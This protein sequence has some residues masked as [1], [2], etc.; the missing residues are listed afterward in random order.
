MRTDSALSDTAS[1][2]DNS[3]PIGD[4]ST[5]EVTD[6]RGVG[7]PGHP[8]RLVKSFSGRE[9]NHMFLSSS[10][11]E[12]S[13]ISAVSGLDAVSDSRSFALLDYDRDG[14]QDIA[15]VNSN[16]PL[17]NL[18]HNEIGRQ[19]GPSDPTGHVVALR[20]HG[21]NRSAQPS[22]RYSAHDGFGAIVT[23]DLGHETLV[24]EHRAGEGFAAQNS[25]TMIVGVGE[26]DVVESVAVAWP[27]G[28]R[29]ELRDVAAGRLLTVFE[30]PAASPTGEAFVVESYRVEMGRDMFT[31]L[32]VAEKVPTLATLPRGPRVR[33]QVP[34]NLYMTMATW[35]AVCARELPQIT[36][37]SE[38]FGQSLALFGLPIDPED[39]TEKLIEYRHRHDPA[40]RLLTSVTSEERAA[41]RATLVDSLSVDGLPSTI[42]TDGEGRVL[43]MSLGL[44]TVSEV[45]RLLADQP[46]SRTR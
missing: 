22:T 37:L 29:Q 34:F 33:G 15:L 11:R 19:L 1:G 43:Q 14:W 41:I 10:G 44:P 46:R 45:R 38:A 36:R 28:S 31:D 2:G 25:A 40:Y 12:F 23:I 26:H 5:V 3:S 27:S 35:C 32:A 16:A 4:L 17:L 9:R 21:G 7:V 20:F 30:D 42:I 18:F 39:S 6:A 8:E 13:D 24:R